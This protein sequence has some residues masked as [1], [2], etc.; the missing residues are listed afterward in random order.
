M[1]KFEPVTGGCL[2]GAVRYEAKA[3]LEEAYYCHCRTCQKSSGAPAEI[4]VFVEPGSLRFTKDAPTFFQSSPFGE[5]GFCAK[6][7]S[8]LV[9][10]HVGSKRP[11]WTN[12]SIG[13]LDH[14]EKARPVVHQCVESQLPW[15]QFDDGLPRQTSE[16]I[17]ELVAAWKAAKGDV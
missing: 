1:S 15:Y 5:R 8:R 2:C 16:D 6:C 4:A 11:E 17:P 13:C 3:N 7:G 10:K 14:P 9:W 12:L